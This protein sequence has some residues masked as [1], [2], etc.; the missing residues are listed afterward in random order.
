MGTPY[1]YSFENMALARTGNVQS[2]LD[3][4]KNYWGGML[5]QGA[6]TF[7]EAY[8]IEQKGNEQYEF[9]DRPYGKSLCHAWSS[10]P[11]AFLPS[12]IF[13]LRPLEDGWKRFSVDPDL[14]R[15]EW[16][17]AT[18]PTPLG[19]ITVSCYK[20]HIQIDIPA[21]TIMDW[22]GRHIEGPCT[23]IDPLKIRLK[24]Q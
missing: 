21:G 1:M 7:W 18:V 23:F 13:G 6:T 4:V 3:R 12:E 16:A 10:G 8:D 5:E 15:L 11:A 19:N 14:G 17:C 20:D 9:Y 22:K 24:V 2:M